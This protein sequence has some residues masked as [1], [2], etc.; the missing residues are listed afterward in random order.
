MRYTTVSQDVLH[1]DHR[2]LIS[3]PGRSEMQGLIFRQGFLQY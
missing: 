2:I 3:D 1:F